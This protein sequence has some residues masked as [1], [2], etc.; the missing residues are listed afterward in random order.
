MCF[1][2]DKWRQF[3][4]TANYLAAVE[5][6]DTVE[7]LHN[8]MEYNL[9]YVSDE[10]DYWQTPEETFIRGAGD[11]EDM[12]RFALDVLVR[13]Q[14]I[15]NARWIAYTG[16]YLKEGKKV[17]SGHAVCVFPLN[18]KYAVFSNNS[19]EY[20]FE[21]YIDIGHDSYPE[22]LKKMEIRDWTGKILET[23]T[24]YYGTF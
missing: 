6:L 3:E 16:Y 5:K 2:K 14:N 22:G 10:K 21:N 12:A 20:N 19:L 8:Y 17:R 18:E 7:K 15:V 24:N 13:I 9:R 4:P 1:V 23:K 11:C